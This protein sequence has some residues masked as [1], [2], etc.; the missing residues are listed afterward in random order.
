[1]QYIIM[2]KS[3]TQKPPHNPHTPKNHTPQ[4]HTH[5]T[6]RHPPRRL[7]NTPH[8]RTPKPFFIHPRVP[9]RRRQCSWIVRR[10]IVEFRVC[11]R[12]KRLG[13]LPDRQRFVIGIEEDERE[14]RC[15]H[16]HDAGVGGSVA[17][18]SDYVQ[19]SSEPAVDCELATKSLRGIKYK[20]R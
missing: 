2:H 7:T 14:A 19:G 17:V 11:R 1:M 4:H 13:R 9:I 5:T 15:V 10:R 6:H 20:R 12:R 8:T 3:S 18:D 16:R